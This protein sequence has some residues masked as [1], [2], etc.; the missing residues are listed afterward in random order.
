[1]NKLILACSFSAIVLSS[2][3]ETANDYRQA[4]GNLANVTDATGEALYQQAQ[5]FQ[6]TNQFT[7]AIR[8]Y[9]TYTAR[10]PLASNAANARFQQANLLFKQGEL[11]KSFD[12]YQEFIERYSNNSLYSKALANQIDVA[13][14]AS[15]GKVK[16]SFLGLKS[17]IASNRAEQML[18]KVRENAPYSSSAPRVQFALGEFWQRKKNAEKAIAAYSEMQ[19]RYPNSSLTPEAIFRIGTINMEQ[20][21]K[22]NRNRAGL[23]RAKYNFEDLIQKYPNHKLASQAKAKLTKL[24]TSNIQ[25]NFDVAEHYRQSKNYQSAA[26][27]YKDVIS[28]SSPSHPLYAKAKQRLT[29]IGQ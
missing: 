2:C 16:T 6:E 15:G 12:S 8:A 27:Y 9:Q 4:T 24:E 26:F 17:E 21:N 29:E 13:I 3:S 11:V 14:A 20:A 28:Q 5:K 23:D 22:G 7:K 19:T 10:N 25:R 1:M 18:I